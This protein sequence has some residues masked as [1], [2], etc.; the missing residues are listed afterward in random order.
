MNED[1]NDVKGAEVNKSCFL[2]MRQMCAKILFSR[3]GIHT[4]RRSL[5]FVT[6]GERRVESSRMT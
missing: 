5:L 1:G 3:T 4:N 6:N 2:G